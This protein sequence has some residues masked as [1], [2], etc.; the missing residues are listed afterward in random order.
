M[1]T[2][3]DASAPTR[4]HVDVWVENQDGVTTSIGTGTVVIDPL[5]I[6]VS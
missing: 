2:G 4:V 6:P 5:S 3:I 1:E